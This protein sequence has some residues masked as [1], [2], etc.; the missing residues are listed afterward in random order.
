MATP[1]DLEKIVS[2]GERLGYKGQELREFLEHERA[3]LTEHRNAEREAKAIEREENEKLREDNEKQ[4][5]AQLALLTA[6]KE[7]LELETEAEHRRLEM[8]LELE[9]MRKE[10]SEMNAI[11][12][13]RSVRAKPPKLPLFDEN[14]DQ[15]DMYLQRFE[16]YAAAQNWREDE[17]A[18]NLSSLLTGKALTV[19]SS[20]PLDDAHRYE[21]LKLALLKA[22]NLTGDGYKTKFKTS[23]PEGSETAAQFATRLRDFIEK[24]L[25]SAGVAS[26]YE[27]ILDFLVQDQFLESVSSE[28]AVFIKEREPKDTGEMARIAERF[29]SAHGGWSQTSQEQVKGHEQPES[30]NAHNSSMNSRN[31]KNVNVKNSSN[32]PTN[33]ND[34]KRRFTCHF[35]HKSGHFWRNCPIAPK[36]FAP[37][38]AMIID[39]MREEFSSEDSEVQDEYRKHSS[40]TS[41]PEPQDG[42]PFSNPRDGMCDCNGTNED[43]IE[44]SFMKIDPTNDQHVDQAVQK[45][46]FELKCGHKV[47]LM[48]AVC[49]VEDSSM[50]LTDGYVGTTRVKVLRDTGCN[51]VIVRSDLVSQN[52][53]T[54][55]Y[56]SCVFIDGTVRKFPVATV[57]IDTSFFKGT[58]SALCVRDPVYA[59][60]LGNI[61]GIRQPSDCLPGSG[62]RRRADRNGSTHTQIRNWKAGGSSQTRT[63]AESDKLFRTPKVR[64]VDHHSQAKVGPPSQSCDANLKRYTDRDRFTVSSKDMVFDAIA[65]GLRRKVWMRGF[66]SR[67][68]VRGNAENSTRK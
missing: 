47:P 15:L 25:N 9:Q 11:V 4:R 30:R 24:W 36:S 53:L 3:K 16:R 5:Q 2:A 41:N 48:S 66:G 17:W 34:D 27:A 68:P 61:E 44:T 37:S 8:Q 12:A 20:I 32:V 18:L 7:K 21:S 23:K 31:G 6:E 10:T 58:V 29:L 1:L 51:G 63:P 46:H 62:S 22:Y 26:T 42:N 64:V 33:A 65:V 67:H 55:Q 45:G 60:V 56:K 35:C 59:L 40:P 13:S 49:H 54:G 19:Y 14:R 43:V 50:P 57:N 38:M 28:F 52:Q 39:V